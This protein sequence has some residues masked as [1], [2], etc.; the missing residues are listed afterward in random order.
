VLRTLAYD[1]R[2]SLR[3]LRK[4]PVLTAT[5]VLV[6]ALGTG[7]VST[8]FSVANAV[9]LRPLPGVSRPAEVVNVQRSQG[10]GGSL[11]ASYLYYKDLASRSKTL[12]G[13]TAWSMQPLTVS[14]GGQGISALGNVVTASY[15]D[16]LGVRPAL[17]RFF[18][19]DEAGDV[20]REPVAVVSYGFWKRELGADSA[21]IGRE[22]R[23][24]GHRFTVIG[25]TPAG[26]A[27]AFPMLRTDVWVP[28]AF[29][30]T[31]TPN[32]P[33]LDSPGAAWLELIGRLAPG[34]TTQSA[35]RELA[36]LSKQF[37]AA[38]GEPAG[39]ARYGS[40]RVSRATGLP[41]GV[42]P[43]VFGFFAVL[44]AVSGLV[45]VI[46][47]VNVAGMLL[48]RAVSRRR[49]V[50][51]RLALGASRARLVRQL[52]TEN[53]VLF[54]IGGLAGMALAVGGTRLLARIDLPVDVPIVIDV[55][56]DSRAFIVT[57]VV[58]LVVGL[59]T[60]LAPALRASRPDLVT[61]LRDGGAGAGRQRSRLRDAMLVAQVAFSLV[62]LAASG[63]FVRALQRGRD[64]NPGFDVNGVATA[65]ID[66]GTSGY[67]RGRARE[68]YRTLA[69]RLE[70]RTGVTAATYARFLPL[71]M[72][73]AGTEI[74]V[75]DYAPP[76]G[77]PGAEVPVA[78]DEVGAGYFELVRLPLVSGRTL[79]AND[80]SAAA[81]VAVVNQAFV[82]RYFG[83]REPVGRTFRLDG[84][85]VTVVGVAR[86]AKFARLDEAPE[87]FM[88]L[89]LAQHWSSN[90][91]LLVRT[92]GDPKALAQVIRDEV[93]ALDPVLPPPTVT[94]FRQ[95]ASVVLLPQRVAATV[96]A[97]LGAIG[98]LL[99]VVGLYGALS[100]SAAQRVRE[101][102]VRLALGATRR[103]VLGLVVGEGLKLAGVGM[104]I[105]LAL[106]LLATRALT[107]FLFGVSPLD[108]ATFLAIGV[109]LG[110]AAF[111][112][113]WLPA[114][115]AA[116]V[117]PA[118]SLRQE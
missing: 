82:K 101:I 22:V 77:T 30:Q 59:A 36:G 105:G 78:M 96:T 80:D 35:Q 93:R 81:P 67:D 20:A 32:G 37:A 95:A 112:A 46:A 102:G 54:A 1:L 28:L 44:L 109:T 107:P 94:T 99:A 17:G 31:L 27:G 43:A 47:S 100:F 5:A 61:G 104:G 55:T 16:V 90:L 33:R 115:K 7:A 69:A 98:L 41:D 52:L 84:R 85:D 12:R 110:G 29:H 48:A 106:A 23:L 39:M 10:V 3:V 57:M 87:P 91:N 25:V 117:D 50:A 63:L 86:D 26:F 2:F 9:V 68:F 66:V 62:L 92:S 15:F 56:P 111:L 70:A 72:N 58:A 14:L 118:I 13:L 60:G 53:L 51:V 89:P 19:P 34:A 65:A 103:H 83:G 18:A 73:T 8:I 49:E 40:A 21:A 4:S 76:G 88:F 11:S 114:R 108:P 38:A 64:V 75:A 97:A 74:S 45:L 71:S 79:R 42:T 113:S 24:N 6:I 116:R